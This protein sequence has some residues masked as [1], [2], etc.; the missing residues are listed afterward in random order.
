MGTG[1]TQKKNNNDKKR[2]NFLSLNYVHINI[3]RK[4]GKR[5]GGQKGKEKAEGSARSPVCSVPACEPYC[6]LA[7]SSTRKS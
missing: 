5:N 6:E 3:S 2:I 1:I 4:E 7:R